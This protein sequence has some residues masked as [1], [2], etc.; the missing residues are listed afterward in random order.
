MTHRAAGRIASAVAIAA[1]LLGLGSPAAADPPRPTNYRS[2]VTDVAPALPEGARVRIVGGD[3]LIELAIPAGHTALVHDYPTSAD[4]A[5]TVP[6]LRF[7]ADGTVR[8]NALA[9]AT[10][11]H[12]SRYG[13]PADVPDPDADPRWETVAT[14]GTYAWHDHRIHWMSPTAPR[15]VDEDGRVDLGGPDGAWEVPITVDGTPTTIT[16]TLEV[17]PAPSILPSLVVFAASLALTLLL[18]RRGLRR[19]SLAGVVAATGAVVVSLATWRAVPPGAGASIVPV[20]VAA[21]A[22]LASVVGVLGPDRARLPATAATAATLVGWGVTRAGVLGHAIL[23]TTLDP[24]VD[25]SVT[26]AAIGV[27]VGLAITLVWRPA[28][29]PAQAAG[30]ALRASPTA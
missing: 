10:P 12:D 13:T 20:V 22:A 11:P 30:P 1:V 26:A 21:I 2:T 18:G 15:A 16:G 24:W 4:A 27:G 14:D 29:L 8:R 28:P 5:S 17:E 23:P 6:Y 7:D 25:R 3:S 9:V 19:T